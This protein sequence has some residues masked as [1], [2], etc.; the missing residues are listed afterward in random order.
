VPAADITSEWYVRLTVTD[1]PGVMSDITR[2][3]AS[4][5]VSIESL[6]QKAS[7][8]NDTN[9]PIVMLTHVAP[10]SVIN[11]AVAEMTALENVQPDFA[12]LR[13]ESFER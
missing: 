5:G 2:I 10:A 6:V 11:E 12:L 8:E 9:V 13:V 3:L 7:Q 4:H 1:V